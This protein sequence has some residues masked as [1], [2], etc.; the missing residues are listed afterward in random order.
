MYVDYREVRGEFFVFILL[1]LFI[2]YTDSVGFFIR[3]FIDIGDGGW[4]N[5][6]RKKL[7]FLNVSN[8]RNNNKIDIY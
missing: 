4:R 5:S 7:V 6:V 3:F 1:L 2:F 8:Y